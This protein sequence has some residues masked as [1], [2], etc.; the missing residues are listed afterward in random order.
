VARVDEKTGAALARRALGGERAAKRTISFHTNAL[1]LTPGAVFAIDGHPRPEVSPAES[2]LVASFASEG[3]H[4]TEWRMRG[5]AVSA[6]RTYR[7]ARVTPKPRIEGVQSAMV[8]GPPAAA[9]PALTENAKSVEVPTDEFGRV[10][11]Q[12]PCNREGRFDRGV[13]CWVRVS[14]GWAG[15]GYRMFTIPRVGHE[16]LVDF[17]E[18]DPDQ[19]VIV[20]RVWNRLSQVPYQL[21]E[22]KTVSTWK[23]RSTPERSGGNEIRLKGA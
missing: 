21:P 13:S 7:P 10:R 23:D 8:V 2:L 17:F 19:P 20:G 11:V 18:R 12:F 3:E 4:D 9:G 5:E 14:Q 15:D 6:A 16:V 1:A 22:H